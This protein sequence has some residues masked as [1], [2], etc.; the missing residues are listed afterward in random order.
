LTDKTHF[1]LGNLKVCKYNEANPVFGNE[2]Y[3]PNTTID[4]ITY[5]YIF[6]RVKPYLDLNTNEAIFYYQ[7]PNCDT[8]SKFLICLPIPIPENIH[9][10]LKRAKMIELQYTSNQNCITV[11]NYNEQ[12]MFNRI[13]DPEASL[14]IHISHGDSLTLRNYFC[15]LS[16]QCWVFADKYKQKLV[17]TDNMDKLLSKNVDIYG[18]SLDK[19]V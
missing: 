2:L 16:T 12:Y 5:E 6:S 1:N 14:F 3:E 18:V 9:I 17:A 10:Y 4:A 7:L 19:I 8:I 15:M 11:T 13:C